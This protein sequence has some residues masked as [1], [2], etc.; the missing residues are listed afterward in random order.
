MI[1]VCIIAVLHIKNTLLGRVIW[2]AHILT[3]YILPRKGCV[4][5]IEI[6][7]LLRAQISS[8]KGVITI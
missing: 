4:M 7:D 6:Y 3:I 5:C 1:P 8:V 2:L